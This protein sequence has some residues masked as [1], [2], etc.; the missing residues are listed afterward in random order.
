MIREMNLNDWEQVKRIYLQGIEQGAATFNTNCPSYEE[1]ENEH[2]KSCRF[3]YEDGDKV[4]GWIALTP[5]SS[6]CVL[7]GCVE[8]SIYVDNDYQGRGIGTELVKQLLCEAKKQGYWSILSTVISI[9]SASVALHKK[10]GFRE[11][12][13][14][15]KIAK[16][17]FGNWQNI[18]LFELRLEN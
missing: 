3:V 4:V 14:R 6:C 16:D 11:V 13:Y 15:E 10:C 8:M 1:W 17:R 18:T 12:G 5:T 9:N 7:K 2:I